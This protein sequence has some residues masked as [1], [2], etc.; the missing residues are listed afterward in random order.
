MGGTE[1]TLR[2]LAT[3]HDGLFMAQEIV[4]A[5][6]RRA[7]IVQSKNATVRGNEAVAQG[8]IPFFFVKGGIIIELRLG[9]AARATRDIDIGLCAP[10]EKLLSA[11]DASLAIGFGDFRLRRWG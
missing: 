4:A 10:A 3:A 9:L 7:L 6:I 8:A 11:F 5:G 2:E 1:D